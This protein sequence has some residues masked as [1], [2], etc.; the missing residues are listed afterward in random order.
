MTWSLLTKQKESIKT[1][2]I[3]S[4]YKTRPLSILF[5]NNGASLC[6]NMCFRIYPPVHQTK[7][8]AKTI[9]NV[10]PLNKIY[11]E[12]ER[13]R[14]NVKICSDNNS[15]RIYNYKYNFLA[16]FIRKSQINTKHLSSQIMRT[17]YILF[18]SAG[19][20]KLIK[21]KILCVLAFI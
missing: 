8:I 4:L 5:D 10:I 1:V 12:R 6:Y 16:L 19:A 3:W 7:L 15:K 14:I 20:P 21:W 13:S 11:L 17:S 2:F 18:G 9:S